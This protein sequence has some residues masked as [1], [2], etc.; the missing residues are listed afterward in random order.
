MSSI[1][2]ENL[3][4]T[5]TTCTSGHK[6]YIVLPLMSG[7]SLNHIISYKFPSGIKDIC[8]L[9]TILRECLQ[10]LKFLHENNLFHRDIKSGNILLS[11]D[12][13]VC[14]GDFGVAAIIKSDTKKNSFV[15][16]YCWMAPEVIARE[17]YDSKVI[18]LVNFCARLIFGHWESQQLKSRKASR[19]MWV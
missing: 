10:G 17:D 4:K 9:A 19:R 1:K 18:F 11:L 12:G 8:I 13:T 16:S 5:Y 15:G 7:G 3:L 6:I 14:L 2:H